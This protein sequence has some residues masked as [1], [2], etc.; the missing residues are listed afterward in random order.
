MA[1]K[2]TAARRAAGHQTYDRSRDAKP[3]PFRAADAALLNR[4]ERRAIAKLKKPNV[5]NG[6]T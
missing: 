5:D 1:K 4:K 6:K 3:D 2:W